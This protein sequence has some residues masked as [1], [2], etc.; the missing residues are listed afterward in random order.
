MGEAFGLRKRLTRSLTYPPLQPHLRC[1]MLREMKSTLLAA[2]ILSTLLGACSRPGTPPPAANVTEHTAPSGQPQPK[3][4]TMKLWLGDKEI[5]V[6]QA[7]RPEQV[8]I[9]M[10]FRTEMAEV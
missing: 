9:G 8:Q 1:G 7:V 4:P 10:M 3:L 2:L 5:I 6:E